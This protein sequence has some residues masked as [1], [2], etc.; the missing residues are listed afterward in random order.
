M[1]KE[2]KRSVIQL[3]INNKILELFCDINVVVS[4]G[5]YFSWRC[6]W[7]K[8]KKKKISQKNHSNIERHDNIRGFFIAVSYECL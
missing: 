1:I 7:S 8:E 5:E 2:F 6:F 3:Y 4:M